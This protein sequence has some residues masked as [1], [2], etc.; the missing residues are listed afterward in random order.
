[1]HDILV[2]NV[3]RKYPESG[4]CS[5]RGP[6]FLCTASD[7][8]PIGPM[9]HDVLYRVEKS[10]WSDNRLWVEWSRKITLSRDTVDPRGPKG[11]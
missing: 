1:M 6:F 7:D 11:R 3:M 2:K 10:T 5:I 8:S 9:T 4:T